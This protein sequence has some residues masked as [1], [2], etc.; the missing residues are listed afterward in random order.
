MIED[1]KTN[2]P[3]NQYE[4]EIDV[5]E[6]K[7]ENKTLRMQEMITQFEMRL[8]GFMWKSNGEKYY[9]T[10]D[11]LLGDK[12]IQDVMFLLHPFSREINMISNKTDFNWQK[13]KLMTRLS[14]IQILVPAV[15]GNVKKFRI[16]WRS[17]SNLLS[18]IGDIIVGK[19][20]QNFLGKIFGNDENDDRLMEFK[21]Y[22]RDRDRRGEGEVI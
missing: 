17:F 12:S 1:Y 4:D 7:L 2:T 10:G 22:G 19:N 6:S 18:N 20:S 15:D 13:Q 11:T 3:I 21:R 16:I 5:S 8:L 9:Y 14:L